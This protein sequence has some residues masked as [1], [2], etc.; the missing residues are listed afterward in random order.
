MCSARRSAPATRSSSDA[1]ASLGTTHRAARRSDAR[2][3][4]RKKRALTEECST[5]SV[6]KVASCSVTTVAARL[7]SGIV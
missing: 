5:G 3:Q 1:V 7:A 4:P 2:V 6:K